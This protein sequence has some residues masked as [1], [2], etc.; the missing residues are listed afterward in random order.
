MPNLLESL[1]LSDATKRTEVS[2]PTVNLRRKMV[3]SLDHQ[4][5][6][7]TAELAGEHYAVQIEKWVETDPGSG[8]KER[9]KI[10]KV[11]RKMWYRNSADAVLLELRFANKPVTISRKPSIMVG[12]AEKLVPT[13]QTVRKAVLAGELDAALKAALD[14]RKSSLKAKNTESQLTK[15][16]LKSGK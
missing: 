2:D 5:A 6:G 14:S 12:P 16:T 1:T 4:I 3:A 11:F 13:L 7:A 8:N 9:R 15:L 10:E